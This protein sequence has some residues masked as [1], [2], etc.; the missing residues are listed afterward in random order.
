MSRDYTNTP[1][2]LA[3]VHQVLWSDLGL[4]HQRW[5]TFREL[6]L[7]SK[8][9]AA[10]LDWAAMGFFAMLGRL[11]IDDV[12]LGIV[13]LA[14]PEEQRLG[15]NL[16]LASVLSALPTGAPSDLRSR[17]QKLIARFEGAAK[18]ARPV[19]NKRLAHRDSEVALGRS[20][21]LEY[22]FTWSQVDACLSVAAEALNAI[23]LF[24]EN[25]QTLFLEFI[26]H[27]G[28]D[29]LVARLAEAK[30]ASDGYFA[31]KLKN[32]A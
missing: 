3:S 14:D 31:N 8:E 4:L 18:F 24:Y 20:T 27:K 19:R 32:P 30:A 25:R 2:N 29:V 26:H 6:F 11:L 13:R 28:P 16:V 10:L 23:E 9:Q 15:D 17:L 1:H 12:L 5:L 22:G 7:H 21:E